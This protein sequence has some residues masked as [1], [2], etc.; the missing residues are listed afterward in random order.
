MLSTSWVL[1]TV[2][3][4]GI[5]ALAWFMKDMKQS[6]ESKISANACDTETNAKDIKELTERFGSYREEV[7]MKY[8]HKD[9]FVRAITNMDKKLDKIYDLVALERKGAS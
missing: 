7:A 2:I 5:G 8:V 1:Q 3:I 9:E 4:V 6:I